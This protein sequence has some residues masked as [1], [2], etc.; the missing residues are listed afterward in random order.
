MLFP[1][2]TRQLYNNFSST[3]HTKAVFFR[4]QS[5]VETSQYCV[6][7]LLYIYNLIITILD[8]CLFSQLFTSYSR[9]EWVP[10]KWSF[11]NCWSRTCYRFKHL[12]SPNQQCFYFFVYDFLFLF[13]VSKAITL[14]LKFYL[15]HL[16]ILIISF[17]T[18]ILG[19]VLIFVFMPYL[20][21]NL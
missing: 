18:A 3:F 7:F 9:S 5:F 1:S 12:P 14:F 20:Y 21:V 4:S 11:G 15:L 2:S 19:Q 13:V 17:F 8:F 6:Q 10:M 16:L